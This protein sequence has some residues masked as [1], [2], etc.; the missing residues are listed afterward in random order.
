MAGADELLSE[1]WREREEARLALLRLNIDDATSPERVF[2]AVTAVAARTLGVDRVGIWTL[3]RQREELRCEHLHDRGGGVPGE[4][5]HLPDMAGY[6]RALR[7]RRAIAVE[8]V[9]ASP[10]LVELA[11]AYYRPHGLIATLDVP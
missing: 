10:I 3:D 4:V 1:R 8:D 11:P 7:D 2:A 6:V 5:L 9:A